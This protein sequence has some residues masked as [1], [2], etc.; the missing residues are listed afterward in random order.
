MSNINFESMGNFINALRRGRG[1]TIEEVAK[2]IGV[3]K[4]AVSQWESG[5]GIKPEM[6]YALARFFDVSV[7][8][9]VAGKRTN[10]SNDDFI[11][12]NYDLS[13]YKFDEDKYDDKSGEKYLTHLKQIKNR[14]FS[15]LKSSV[16]GDLAGSQKAEFN[17]LKQYFQR[18]DRYLANLKYGPEYIC[19]FNDN[20][21]AQIIK[22]R[23]L[24]LPLDD[25]KA[26]DWELSKFYSI[27]KEYLKSAL[28]CKTQ[29]DYLLEKLLMVM[30]QPE[31][32]NFLAANLKFKETHSE[33]NGLVKYGTSRDLTTSEIEARPYL[34]TMLNCNCHCMKQFEIP[35][36]LDKED[37]SCIEGEVINTVEEISLNSDIAPYTYG[38][39]GNELIGSLRCWETYSYAEYQS[40]IDVKKTEY[41]K[42]IV[43]LKN[44]D[45]LAYYGA[46]QKYCRGE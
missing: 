6:L 43:N 28:V 37:L 35:S 5:N 33:A 21:A 29:S 45:P 10:E 44:S 19:F 41:Y 18:D 3:S 26:I 22:N 32:D 12:R 24:G 40:F 31:K 46:L 42:A 2:H 16:F 39:D 17:F 30:N 13:L 15:L 8:E 27:K 23:I 7:D 20:D 9:L 38:F 25:E 11:K 14:F 36:C 34:K 4:P 1:L